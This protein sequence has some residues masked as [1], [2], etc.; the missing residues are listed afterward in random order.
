MHASD[1]AESEAATAQA[2]TGWQE[3]RE[4]IVDN[5]AGGGG[6]SLGIMWA[7][8]R[9][10][11]IA[12]NH[13][14]AA[15]AMYKANFPDTKVYCE[16][17][18]EVD[19]VEATQGRPVAL[20]WFS[21]DCTHFSK[22]KG[23]KPVDKNIRGLAYVVLKWAAKVRPRVIML[24]NVEEFVTWGPVRKGRPVKSKKGQ[25]F[26][27]WKSQLES[28]GYKV[29]HRELVACDYGAPTSRKRFFLIARRD[30]RPI[31]WPEPTHGDPDGLMI[32]CGLLKPWRAAAECIDWS[33]PCP[34]IFE[35][36]AEIKAKYGIRVKRPLAKKHAPPN[37]PGNYEVRNQQS[38]TVYCPNMPVGIWRGWYAVQHTSAINNHYCASKR[39]RG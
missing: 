29:E 32:R 23:G 25:T 34:S 19:P 1:A 30:G 5:F 28:L 10:V 24:E 9:P 21:P 26:R 20:A 17:I 22:A 3:V 13:D 31:V 8:G 15:I 37:S 12:I 27:L 11:D 7:T 38:R 6:A 39:K 16:N 35:S 4:L 18:W 33:I 14:P 2:E 36:A